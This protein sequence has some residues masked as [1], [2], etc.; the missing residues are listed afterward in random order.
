MQALWRDVP[1]IVG[2]AL[3]V[4]GSLAYALNYDQAARSTDALLLSFGLTLFFGFRF[5]RAVEANRSRPFNLAGVVVAFTLIL[6][7][8]AA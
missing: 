1:V 2:L 4:I 6:L 3:Y 7:S 8:I 5:W